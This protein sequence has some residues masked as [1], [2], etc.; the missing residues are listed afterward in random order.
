MTQ[1]KLFGHM[2]SVWSGLPG[3]LS[4]AAA[5]D[6]GSGVSPGFPLLSLAAYGGEQKKKKRFFGDYLPPRQG[7]PNPGKGLAAQYHLDKKNGFV[8]AEL[9]TC[10]LCL[11]GTAF[12]TD[13]CAF[14]HNLC[15][16]CIY[17]NGIGLAALCNPAWEADESTS[18]GRSES[19]LCV[20]KPL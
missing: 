8:K 12:S 3:G 2:F 13:G 15:V 18:N 14:P 20:M 5:P 1:S 7:S 16:D 6:R 17:L 9:S 4:G 11:D 10:N 19:L